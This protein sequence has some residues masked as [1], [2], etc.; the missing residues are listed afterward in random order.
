[1]SKPG[2]VV[3]RGKSDDLFRPEAKP[4]FVLGRC[5]RHR[6]EFDDDLGMYVLTICNGAFTVVPGKGLPVCSRCG[7]FKC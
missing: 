4:D 5:K 6:E 7:H 1:M 3:R 2:E